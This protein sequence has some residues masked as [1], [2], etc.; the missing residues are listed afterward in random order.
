MGDY[1]FFY[2]KINCLLVNKFK[3]KTLHLTPNSFQHLQKESNMKKSILLMLLCMITV[4]INSQ[5]ITQNL[6]NHEKR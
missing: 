4:I 2:I 5:S 3:I 1:I 6:N